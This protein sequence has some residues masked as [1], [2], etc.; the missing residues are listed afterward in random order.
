[1]TDRWALNASPMICLARAGYHHLLTELPEQVVVPEAV[2]A[3]VNAGPQGDPAQGILSGGLFTIVAVEALP[4]ILA[5]DLGAGETA[6]L[7]YVLAH[8]GWQAVL[9]DRAARKCARALGI[10]VK[11]TLS[12][13]LT[14]RK[15]GII[16]SAAEVLRALQAAGLWLEDDLIRQALQD[17]VGEKW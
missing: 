8:P 1:M 15:Q 2:V 12:V 4:S 7:S 10:T 11:G 14:A 13:V 17:I 16:S 6:V 5:W 9:D 3:E